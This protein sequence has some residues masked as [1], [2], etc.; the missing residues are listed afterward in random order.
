MHSRLQKSKSTP[1]G[2]ERPSEED[3]RSKIAGNKRDNGVIVSNKA[4][5]PGRVAPQQTVVGHFPEMV[6]Y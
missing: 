5:H 3:T 6:S 4:G 2:M 1:K